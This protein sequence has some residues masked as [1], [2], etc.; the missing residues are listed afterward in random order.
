MVHAAVNAPDAWTDIAERSPPDPFSTPQRTPLGGARPAVE[1]SDDITPAKFSRRSVQSHNPSV[2]SRRSVYE[3]GT[4]QR[5]VPQS[6]A[7]AATP[8]SA[9]QSTPVVAVR[10]IAE[11]EEIMW[12]YGSSFANG[13][14]ADT[15]LS[16]SSGQPSFEDDIDNSEDESGSRILSA[17]PL[18]SA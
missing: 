11:G 16:T 13:F 17:D 7:S 5:V 2:D 3:G 18:A 14:D 9:V 8:T 10:Q 1:L 12:N 6:V 4:P 15:V